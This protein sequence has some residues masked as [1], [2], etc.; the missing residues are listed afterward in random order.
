MDLSEGD[1]GV[2]ILNDGKYGC[3]IK[4][5]HMRIT[6]IK[7]ATF[8]D[9]SQDLGRHEFCYSLYPHQGE[10]KEAHVR[11]EAY[12][13]NQPLETIPGAITLCSQPIV[14]EED[15]VMLET[16]K[17]AEAGDNVIL[18]FYEHHGKNH[19]MKV[20]WNLPMKEVYRC[21]ILERSEGDKIPVNGSEFLL[22][23]KPFEIVTVK[24]TV[25]S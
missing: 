24:L 18:R 14:C 15:G 25:N 22:T 19:A 10:E 4:D 16:L 6:L 5:N 7:T 3:D 13:L 11:E 20:K 12:L 8:P 17:M 1:H 21:D 23:V 2:A 9:E